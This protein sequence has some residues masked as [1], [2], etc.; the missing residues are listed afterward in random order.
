MEGKR[1]RNMQRQMVTRDP[2]GTKA[3]YHLSMCAVFAISS[4]SKHLDVVHFF[5]FFEFYRNGL[6]QDT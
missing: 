4:L 6:N 5:S 1:E 2:G 3:K